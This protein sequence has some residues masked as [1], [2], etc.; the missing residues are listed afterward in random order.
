MAL[1]REQSEGEL[2]FT[3]GLARVD[4]LLQTIKRLN[5]ER[6]FCL[7]DQ[8]LDAIPM[9]DLDMIGQTATTLAHNAAQ[10]LDRRGWMGEA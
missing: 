3:E 10:S 9:E 7:L 4:A 1:P 6:G 5:H 2:A 8:V